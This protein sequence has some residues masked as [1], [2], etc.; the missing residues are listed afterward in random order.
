MDS[1]QKITDKIKDQKTKLSKWK[2]IIK[3]ELSKDH[4]QDFPI[5]IDLFLI[6]KEW[7]HKYEKKFF[8]VQYNSFNDKDLINSYNNFDKINNYLI[9]SSSPINFKFREEIFIFNKTCCRAF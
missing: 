8:N 6:R 7:L 3:Q 9:T 4:I 1:F 2:N 5:Q